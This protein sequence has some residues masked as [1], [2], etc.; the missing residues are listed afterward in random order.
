MGESVSTDM[1]DPITFF[2]RQTQQLEQE[3][4]YGE[5]SL[6]WIYGSPLGKAALHTLVKRAV[7]SKF[8]GWL[9]NRPSSAQKIAPFIA[10]YGLD[11]AEFA[12]P[13]SHFGHFNDFF[14]RKLKRS[15]RPIDGNETSVVFPADGRHLLVPD[16]VS[17][18]D[19]FAKGC[20]FSLA[21][22][23]RDDVLTQE[24]TGC[25]ALISRLCPTDYHR[26]HFPLAGVPGEPHLI[27]GPLFSVSPIALR[28]RP[29]ILWENKRYLTQVDDTPAGRMLY[30]EIGATCVGSVLHTSVPGRS[31]TKGDEKGTFFFGGSSVMTLFTKG[32]VRWDADLVEHSAQGRELFALMGQHAGEVLQR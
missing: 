1:A 20:T 27:N 15:A 26:F 29:S 7:F 23:L 22:L 6:R 25:S 32:S 4:I 14:S 17:C 10:Q 21:A 18:T 24:F 5:A 11:P 2:N 28:Q 31:T 12:E 9:M 8:Y 13:V 3:A 30:L 19:L 16:V